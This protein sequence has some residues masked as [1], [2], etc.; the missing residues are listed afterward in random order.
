MIAPRRTFL[1]QLV[2]LP[3]IGGGV[4]LIGEPTAVA[5]PPSRHTLAH[6]ANWLFYERRILCHELAN[7]DSA[8]A[9]ELQRRREEVEPEFHFP[10]HR[11]WRDVP[12]PSTRAA[13]I[14]S[15][16]GF[17]WHGEGWKRFGTLAVD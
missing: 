8:F 16:A 6:Y 15:A 5:E 9:R 3:L 12:M 10:P 17:D 14:M 4:T 7:G 1:R 11:D 2:T 13:L